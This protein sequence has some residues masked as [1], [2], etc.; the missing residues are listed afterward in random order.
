MRWLGS[1]VLLLAP[2]P[3]L[4]WL[5]LGLSSS[6]LRWPCCR[7]GA[8]LLLQLPAVALSQAIAMH[9]K[10][11]GTRR[12]LINGHSNSCTAAAVWARH[13]THR[14]WLLLVVFVLLLMLALGVLLLCCGQQ[15]ARCGRGGS[16][17]A[18]AGCATHDAVCG[19]LN[20]QLQAQGVLLLLHAWL[21]MVLLRGLLLG[22]P[23]QQLLQEGPA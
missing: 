10:G 23:G 5:L 2:R 19:H 9:S 7:R 18:A 20:L 1:L 12:L 13:D 16:H 22:L 3:L 4:A 17:A 8:Q 11:C 14:C 21:L 15:A 6:L